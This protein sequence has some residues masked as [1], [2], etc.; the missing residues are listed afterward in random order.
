MSKRRIAIL[1]LANP[2]PENVIPAYVAD[3][4]FFSSPL[5]GVA[6][7]NIS[8]F[9]RVFMTVGKS[10]PTSNTLFSV[11]CMQGPTPFASTM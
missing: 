3:N 8:A 9:T 1:S 7:R 4:H 6:G 2:I 5:E 10:Q 11:L